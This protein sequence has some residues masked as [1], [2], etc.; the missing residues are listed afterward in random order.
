MTKEHAEALVEAS[1]GSENELT[2]FEGYSGRGMY[3]EQTWGVSGSHRGF[4]RAG[5]IAS[6]D[7]DEEE[8]EDFMEEISSIRTDSL[9]L[10]IIF[11]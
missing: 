11:Y 6:R 7:F 2:I 1:E 10:D 4:I 3:G 8:A 9:G 5:F